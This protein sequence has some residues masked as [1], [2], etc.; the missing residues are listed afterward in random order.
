DDAMLAAENGQG[1]KDDEGDA[2]S[3]AIDPKKLAAE[4]A[5]LDGYL[6]LARSIGSNSKG[7]KLL[8]QLPGVLDEVV[9]RGGKRKAVIFTE[10]VRTQRYLAEILSQS[11]YDG[12]IVLMNG[13]NS[14]K[15]SQKVYAAWKKEKEG[16]DAVS[17]SKSADMKSAI[18]SAFKSDDKSI[19]IATESGAEGINL[20]FCSLIINFD[21]P[22]NPQRIEQRI[23]RCHRYGQKI[24]VTVV[25]M[26]NLKNQAE[27]RIHD[28]LKFK[29]NL[30]DGLFGASDQ[31]LGSIE[32]GIDFERKV[33]AVVQSCRTEAQV[34][35]A[36]K[37]LE[38]ELEEQI[39]ADMAETR[40]Q[41]FD[42]F[43]A[44]IVDML[45]Q[46]GT[47]IER[48]MS[49]F[50]RRLWLLAR[51]ELPEAK[52]HTDGIARFDHDGKTWST[53]WP[54]ADEQGWQFFRLGDGTLAD[55]LVEVARTRDLP[56]TKLAFDY[57]VYRADGQ[58][59]LSDLEHV[60]GKSGWLKVS[61]LKAETAM[62]SRDS[63]VIAAVTDDGQVLA[64]E[65]AERLFQ[66]PAS[67]AAIDAEY[68]AN[69]MAGIDRE[70]LG[71]AQKSAEDENRKWLEEETVK[72]EA[73]AE[74]LEKSNDIRVRE[75]DLEARN[76]RRALRANQAIPLVEKVAEERRIKKLEG[77]R[78]DLKMSTFQ[79]LREIR[80]EVDSKLDEVAAK[81]AITPK[82]TPLLTVRWE[83][84]S[85]GSSLWMS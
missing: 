5:E 21:L 52:F 30:F 23:G 12:Q 42:L 24:D 29:F 36:F 1:E 77:E 20:Q 53:A 56:E 31:V 82:V 84:L 74:D 33:L 17:G 61:L 13:S 69:R 64:S 14:D 40:Q 55:R 85:G 59:R 27:K 18:V 76:A 50:E 2:S 7:D 47:E 4:I 34:D 81:L 19:L 39:K 35:E 68:P 11:G 41:L 62:G 8:S 10:S 63:I 58:P 48:T 45:R 65:T 9:A 78:D 72:L 15:E 32:S 6:A 49:D 28:L 60:G 83:V 3:D 57:K 70:A 26:L 71:A 22:W 44:S 67:I 79:T 38:S 51:A 54:Q 75:L 66:I 46:R 16:T 37:K 43:D 25:N 80:K 73:Y